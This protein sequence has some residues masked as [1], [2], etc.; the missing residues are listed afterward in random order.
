MRLL[1]SPG[2]AGALVV[3]VAMPAIAL[4]Q[5]ERG[6]A[7]AVT[8]VEDFS[9]QVEQ[10]KK[11]FGDIGTKIEESAKTI[12]G[13]TDVGKARKEIEALRAVVGDLLGAVSDNGLVSQLGSKALQH[14]R[15]KLKTLAEDTRFTREERDFLIKEWGRLVEQTER[16]SDDL[17]SARKEFAQLLRVLQTRED[18]I[19]ELMQI[20]RASEAVGVIRKLTQEIRDAS[21]KLKELMRAIKPPGV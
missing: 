3:L 7:D 1:A 10:L 2:L 19:D 8:P 11:S 6:S 9:R 16:A 15:E 13:M 14:A 4:A 12:D 5:Q 17:A 20:R 18:F 21:E